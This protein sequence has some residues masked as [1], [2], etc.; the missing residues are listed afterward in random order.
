MINLLTGGG[1]QYTHEGLPAPE[2]IPGPL[3]PVPPIDT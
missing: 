1:N 3:V 2:R